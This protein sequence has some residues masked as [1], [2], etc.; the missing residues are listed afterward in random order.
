[1]GNKSLRF[2]LMFIIL[3][4]VIGVSNY[5]LAVEEGKDTYYQE[6]VPLYLRVME[7]MSSK[8]VTVGEQV[9]M[10]VI[11]SVYNKQNNVVIPYGSIAKGVVT[12]SKKANFLGRTGLIEIEINSIITEAGSHEVDLQYQMKGGYNIPLLLL[13]FLVGKDVTIPEN[14]II[15]V[16]LDR[17][18]F[19]GFKESVEQLVE[20][21]KLEIESPVDQSVYSK[22]SPIQFFCN[23]IS[24]QKVKT[25][26]LYSNNKLIYEHGGEPGIIR[27]DKKLG[28]GEYVL[29]AKAY[30]E[31]GQIVSDAIKIFKD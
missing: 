31:D 6:T 25:F 4:L 21:P 30:L 12:K 16:Q 2:L 22:N 29:V 20:S 10:K 18:S 15:V 26:K 28:K 8:T 19:Y 3:M 7:F 27:L 11:R 24:D 13:G 17:Y 1:M 9:E 23:I 5:V 14:G